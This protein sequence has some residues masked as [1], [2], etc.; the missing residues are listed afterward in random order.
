MTLPM[1]LAAL[2]IAGGAMVIV[3]LGPAARA[4]S[5]ADVPLEWIGTFKFKEVRPHRAVGPISSSISEQVYEVSASLRLREAVRVPVLTVENGRERTT[6]EFV[7]LIDAGS[8]FTAAYSGEGKHRN[9][10]SGDDVTYSGGRAMALQIPDGW[11]YR[12]LAADDPLTAEVPDGSY[13]LAVSALIGD[14]RARV[15]WWTEAR[16]GT[17]H[18]VEQDLLVSTFTSG[19]ALWRVDSPD[20]PLT[21]LYSSVVAQAVRAMREQFTP[22]NFGGSV[23]F[24]MQDGR[25]EGEFVNRPQLPAPDYLQSA[26][27]RLEK[28]RDVGCVVSG[29]PRSWRPRRHE[30]VTLT[31]SLPESLGLTGRFRFELTGISRH[32]GYATNAGGNDASL[33]LRFAEGQEGFGRPEESGDTLA[34]QSLEPARE[35]RVSIEPLD[36]GAS[37]DLAASV[38]ID[39]EW[40]DCIVS[41]GDDTVQIPL[42]AD[43]NDIADVF[44]TLWETGRKDPKT[45]DD[46]RPVGAGK[47][48]GFTNFEEYRGFMV[49]GAWRAGTPGIKDLFVYDGLGRGIGHF[50]KTGINVHLAGEDDFDAATRIVNL[51]R[52]VHARGPQYALKMIE[53]TAPKIGTLG[54]VWPD[55]GTPAE[56][57][58]ITIDELRHYN[59]PDDIEEATWPDTIAHE[60]GHAVDIHHHGE[61]EE[62]TCEPGTMTG[63]WRGVHAGDESC[64][65]RYDASN[66]YKDK[67]GRC[68]RWT[69]PSLPGTTFCVSPDGTGINAGPD[70]VS[71]EG[72]PMPVSGNAM[73]GNCMSRIRLVRP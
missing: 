72:S 47:G 5:L 42:D 19:P 16:R 45:D 13:N 29:V 73:R 28:K 55:V 66:Y 24:V 67:M 7:Q 40:H 71:P 39:G 14:L 4:Q 63:L 9:R 15:D 48:D 46:A 53:G 23:P 25:M 10:R 38:E 54:W 51:H 49:M 26:S 64:V 57:T 37:A 65:M 31:A 50:S 11:I 1:R 3:S 62:G 52:A 56:V 32:P 8:E 18:H 35:Q 69:W 59:L 33:D 27:W 70:R 41:T 12:S 44:D 30:P 60:I 43:G 58:V 36:Y 34:I 68:H 21:H 20:W 6:G 17:R 61:W 22:A 2:A